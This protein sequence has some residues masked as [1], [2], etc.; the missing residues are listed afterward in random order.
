MKLTADTYTHV[1]D[2]QKE[3]AMNKTAYLYNNIG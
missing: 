2:K 3:K 1:P